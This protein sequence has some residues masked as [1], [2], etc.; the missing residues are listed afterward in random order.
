MHS[1]TP[2]ARWFKET[3]ATV[4]GTARAL[5]ISRARLY[6]YINANAVPTE[7]ISSRLARVTGLGKDQF[8]KRV[9]RSRKG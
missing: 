2:L 6:H 3:G 4:A 8:V 7:P 1:R 9:K 5:K